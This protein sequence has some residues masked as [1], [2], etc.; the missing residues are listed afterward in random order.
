MNI[1]HT[2][3]ALVKFGLGLTTFALLISACSGSSSTS[4]TSS[5][6]SSTSDPV[7]G[8]TTPSKVSV[9]STN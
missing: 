2:L 9:V 4:S 6:S 7:V 3:T 8:V 1:K 5:T